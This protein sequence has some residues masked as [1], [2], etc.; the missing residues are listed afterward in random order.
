MALLLD[1]PPSSIE[2]LSARDSDLLNVSATESIDLTTKLK[3][4]ADD[5]EMAVESMLMS[6]RPSYN[7]IYDVTRK[8]FPS[9]RHVAVTP[10]LK[11]W[12]TYTTLRLI[13]QDLYYSRLNDRYRAKMQMYGEEEAQALDDLRTLGFGIVFDPLPQAPAPNI[14]TVQTNDAGGTMYI[15]VTFVNERGEEGLMSVPVEVTTANNSAASVSIS[16]LPENA[17]GWNL[18]GGLSPEALSRQNPQ[19]LGPLDYTT[20]APDNLTAGTEP[21]TGQ[22]GNVFYPVPRRILRG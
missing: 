21:G 6:M 16:K 12:N 19:T 10:Q 1:G 4:A 2:D 20:A 9:I 3:L 14:G 8:Y 17:S 5:I 22:H 11:L 13:Y 7:A 15:G 18:Y